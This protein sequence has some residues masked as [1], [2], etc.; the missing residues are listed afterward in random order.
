MNIQPA[1]ASEILV[2]SKL[3]NYSDSEKEEAARQLD[4]LIGVITLIIVEELK[5]TQSL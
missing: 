1:T 4:E 5:P 2:N 3:E